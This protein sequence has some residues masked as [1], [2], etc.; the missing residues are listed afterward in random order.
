LKR[1][2]LR[3]NGNGGSTVDQG[4]SPEVDV[5]KTREVRIRAL[6]ERVHEVDLVKQTFTVQVQF[7]ARWTDPDLKEMAKEANQ[8]GSSK[9]E[10]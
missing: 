9:A 4:E 3:Q 6:V 5:N 10:R 1:S 7:E 8:L 2:C